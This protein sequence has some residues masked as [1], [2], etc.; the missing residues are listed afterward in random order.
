MSRRAKMVRGFCGP[1][2][3]LS[4]ASFTR[5]RKDCLKK[6]KGKKKEMLQAYCC[7]HS[8]SLQEIVLR[9][10]RSPRMFL[11]L[12]QLLEPGVKILRGYCGP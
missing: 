12:Q 8:I 6:I 7:P 5:S 11:S 4:F 10:Y 3:L 2:I 1:W 9:G